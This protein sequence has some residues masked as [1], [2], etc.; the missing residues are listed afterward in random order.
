MARV[1]KEANEIH[2]LKFQQVEQRGVCVCAHVA[3]GTVPWAVLFQVSLMVLI[4]KWRE[5]PE[6]A[7]VLRLSFPQ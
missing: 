2:K 5:L 1:I 6:G 3:P 7:Q 4:K